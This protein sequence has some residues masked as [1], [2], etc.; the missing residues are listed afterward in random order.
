MVEVRQEDRE[1]FLEHL[2][3][4]CGDEAADCR[5][6]GILSGR[7]DGEDWLVGFVAGRAAVE[8][9]VVEWLLSDGARL[10]YEASDCE[11]HFAWW[12]ADAIAA[13][14]HRKETAGSVRRLRSKPNLR[15]SNRSPIRD[16]RFAPL[17]DGFEPCGVADEGF[18][19]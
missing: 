7:E 16:Q 8:R 18:E 13:G 10:D 14:Q 9:A 2:R 5:E 15:H 1:A 4:E 6:D 19:V 17:V 12:A 11:E 3:T